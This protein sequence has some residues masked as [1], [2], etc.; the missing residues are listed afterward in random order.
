MN[1]TCSISQIGEFVPIAPALCCKSCI[2]DKVVP[3]DSCFDLNFCSGHGVC[4]LGVC[5]CQ[6]GFGGADCKYRVRLKDSSAYFKIKLAW[7]INCKASLFS[8]RLVYLS[9]WI[10]WAA[11]VNHWIPNFGH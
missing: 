1:V 7:I 3:A 8:D 9:A 6:E 2:S 11:S 10:L 4:N 5:E